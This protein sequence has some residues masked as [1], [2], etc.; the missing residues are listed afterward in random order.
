LVDRGDR[1]IE[2]LSEALAEAFRTGDVGEVFSDD[3]FLDSHPPFWRFQLE[4]LETFAGWLRAD[5]AH[6]P[7]VNV[8]RTIPT[9]TGFVTEHATEHIE[10]SN[11]ITS[12]KVLIC[13]VRGGRVAEMTVYCSGP[14]DARLR[15]RHAVEAPMSRP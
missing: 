8:V 15:A 14:W 5:A 7:T 12:R 1:T 10:D 6:Q 2:R 9:A 3:L 13:A 4:G 11:T